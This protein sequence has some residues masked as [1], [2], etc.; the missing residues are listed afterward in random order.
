MTTN[1]KWQWHVDSEFSSHR[2]HVISK[3]LRAS[4]LL[5][6]CLRSRDASLYTALFKVYVIPIITYCSGLYAN[7]LRRSFERIQKIQRLFT[8]KL[9]MRLYPKSQLPDYSSRLKELGLSRLSELFV[10]NDLRTLTNIAHGNMKSVAARELLMG[11]G[12]KI[13]NTDYHK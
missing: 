6:R 2:S 12:L 7:P 11:G 1:D 10:S 4:G 3:A 8:R 5:F 9:Y 13:N